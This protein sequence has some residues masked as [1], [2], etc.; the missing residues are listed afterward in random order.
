MGSILEDAQDLRSGIT[1]EPRESSAK[2]VQFAN[3]YA[4]TPK[5]K[6]SALIL[7]FN[8]GRAE[9]PQQQTDIQQEMIDL[10]EQIVK[11]NK[12][13]SGSLKVKAREESLAKIRQHYLEQ[14]LPNDPVFECRGITKEYPS[15]AFKLGE[16]DLTLRL[17][18][19]TGVVGQNANG[20]TTLLRIVAGELRHNQGNIFYPALKQG[21]KNI[22]WV[23]VKSK[24]AYVPQELPAWY[25]S[26]SDNLHYE[27]AVH[28]ILGKENDEEVEYVVER[29]GLGEHLDKGWQ[30]L[31]GGYKLR[32][33]LAKV[34]I[35]KPVLLIMDE[36]L[37]SLDL[38][39]QT[40]LLKDVRDLA[41]SLRYPMSVLMS[42]Q[43]LH[44]V[45]A[46]SDEMV[47]LRQGA[48]V[49]NGPVGD[50]GAD[51]THNVFELGSSLDLLTLRHRLKDARFTDVYYN[52]VNYVL[53]TTYETTYREVLEHL[54]EKQ[55]DI[56][57]FRDISRSTKRL[58]D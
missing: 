35:W 11:D 56:L 25:G 45:E 9:L 7:R 15:S 42:S 43:D 31:S 49:Y 4:I 36:P 1:A 38:K 23:K 24:I 44:E 27:A 12:V 54:L 19:I 33:S 40:I 46:V 48:I 3:R 51:R 50:I 21:G 17:G 2:L 55:I 34:L 10:V 20:K 53:Q 22:D 28:G 52:G 14:Q 32:F 5:L 13:N 18:R 16:I 30:E 39:A 58:F 41:R 47:F 6:N 8:Y 37:A 26:L 29:L 57:Y